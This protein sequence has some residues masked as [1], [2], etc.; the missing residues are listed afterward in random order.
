MNL[1]L[2]K[3]IKQAVEKHIAENMGNEINRSFFPYH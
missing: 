1:N 3:I 2:E